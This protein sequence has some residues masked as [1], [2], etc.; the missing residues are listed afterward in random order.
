[1]RSVLKYEE[2]NSSENDILAW[3]MGG[4]ERCKQKRDQDLTDIKNHGLV[5][6]RIGCLLK[7][8]RR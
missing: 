1:M 3:G 5:V 4:M 6:D 7:C 8:K 2:G